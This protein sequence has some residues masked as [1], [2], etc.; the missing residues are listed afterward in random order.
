MGHRHCKQLA[1]DMLTVLSIER[2]DSCGHV[3]HEDSRGSLA[4]CAFSCWCCAVLSVFFAVLRVFERRE[5]RT[6]ELNVRTGCVGCLRHFCRGKLRALVAVRGC[7]PCLT[8]DNTTQGFGFCQNVCC[9]RIRTACLP[10]VG[11][12]TQ[13]HNVYRRRVVCQVPLHPATLLAPS[14]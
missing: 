1:A 3:G 12:S 13:L 6:V 14:R 7:F 8:V 2:G 10:L 5:S 11:W 9:T 4:A